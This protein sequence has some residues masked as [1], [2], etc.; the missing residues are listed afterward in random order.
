M[1][2]SAENVSQYLNVSETSPIKRGFV[3]SQILPIGCNLNFFNSSEH[4]PTRK[5]KTSSIKVKSF[6]GIIF[7][8]LFCINHYL[9]NKYVIYN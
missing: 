2:K 4:Y 6:C 9:K 5:V 8:E 3:L 1:K 7:E